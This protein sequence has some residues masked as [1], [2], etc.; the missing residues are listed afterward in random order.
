MMPE[1]GACRHTWSIGLAS[2]HPA[3][4]A[5]PPTAPGCCPCNA[6]AQPARRAHQRAAAGGA[7]AQPGRQAQRIGDGCGGGGRGGGGGRW[8]ACALLQGG[9]LPCP[10]RC[11]AP[12]CSPQ[13]PQGRRS[14]APP[15]GLQQPTAPLTACTA[16]GRRR[17]PGAGGAAGHR[18]AA[19]PGG[20]PVRQEVPGGEDEGTNLSAGGLRG[21]A[22]D[23]AGAGPATACAHGACNS[24]WQVA[25][26]GISPAA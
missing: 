2:L 8:A 18:A 21:P 3:A 9:A 16:P 23:Q 25:P 11:A 4:A 1:P 10:A 26:P 12:C 6:G 17:Q 13:Q 22:F 19:L 24:L 7:R 5:W 14:A 20:A 15:P